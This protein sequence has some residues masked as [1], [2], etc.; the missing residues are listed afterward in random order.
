MYI[1]C[2]ARDNAACVVLQKLYGESL[3]RPY[4]MAEDQ[5]EVQQGETADDSPQH[6][7]RPVL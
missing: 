2:S 1:C 3:I 7:R 6:N 5:G 4:V